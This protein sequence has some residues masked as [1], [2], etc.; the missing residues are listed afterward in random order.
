MTDCIYCSREIFEKSP[1]PFG[2][3]QLQPTVL[4]KWWH[5][6]NKQGLVSVSCDNSDVRSHSATPPVDYETDLLAEE[7]LKD[8]EAREN[9]EQVMAELEIEKED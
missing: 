3:T 9:A 5:R 8:E 7:S 6:S 1:N 4:F 2:T